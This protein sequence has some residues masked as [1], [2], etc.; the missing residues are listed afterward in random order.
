MQAMAVIEI[1][2]DCERTFGAEGQKVVCRAL[3]KIGLDVGHQI[4][5]DL[6]KPNSMTDENLSVSLFQ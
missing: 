1:L 2:K 3:Q 4:L 5:K 6:Q